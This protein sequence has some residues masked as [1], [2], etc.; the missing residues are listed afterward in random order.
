MPR[1]RCVTSTASGRARSTSRPSSTGGPPCY[2]STGRIT[3]SARWEDPLMSLSQKIAAALDA[4]PDHGAFPCDVAIDDGPNRLTIHLTASGP[5][6][7]AFDALDF[8]T[9][10]RAEWSADELKA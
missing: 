6:G 7:L 8:A 4:R 3:R 10:T 2:H 9:A 1:T 5:V